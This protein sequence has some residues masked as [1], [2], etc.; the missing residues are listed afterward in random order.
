MLLLQVIKLLGEATDDLKDLVLNRGRV[1]GNTVI[2]LRKFAEQC[3]G[4]F[5]VGGDDDITRLG[6]RDI[7]GNFLA[8]KDVAQVL[9]QMLV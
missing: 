6:V 4:D 8:Q 2:D 7:Q 5:S 9:G 1:N 3:L